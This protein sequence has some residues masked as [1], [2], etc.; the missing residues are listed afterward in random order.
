MSVNKC[1]SL[2]WPKVVQY[3]SP[4]TQLAKLLKRRMVSDKVNYDGTC[5]VTDIV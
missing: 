4:A 5:E 2:N 1:E 3:R